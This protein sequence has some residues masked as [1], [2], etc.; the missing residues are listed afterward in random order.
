MM[1][2]L[3]LNTDYPEFLGWLYAQHP[4]PE[5]YP[6]SEQTWKGTQSVF[7]VA[8]FLLQQPAQIET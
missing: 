8:G 7:S 5:K 3:I 6:Y 2:F 1:K 4:G